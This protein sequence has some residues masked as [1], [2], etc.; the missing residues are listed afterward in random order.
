MSLPSLFFSLLGAITFFGVIAVA[1]IYFLGD[2]FR[3]PGAHA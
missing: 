2:Q 1:V 3:G